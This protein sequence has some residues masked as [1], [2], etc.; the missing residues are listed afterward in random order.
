MYW[1][2]AVY[3]PLVDHLDQELNDRLLSQEN[4]FLGQYLVPAKLN[5]SNSGK[6]DKLYETYKTDLSKKRDFDNEILRWQTKWSHS[7]DEKQVT[8]T[9][10]LH[11]SRRG[12]NC[13]HS[14]DN[15]SVNC[16][17]RTIF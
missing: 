2:R 9:E 10:T 11:L 12:H 1:Q 17:P 13:Y 14:P 7:T 6:Q 5:A 4:R 15:A 8:L 16:Y 3:F